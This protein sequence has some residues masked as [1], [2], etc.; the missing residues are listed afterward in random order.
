MNFGKLADKGRIQG[1][2]TSG[3]RRS[4]SQV[5]QRSEELAVSGAANCVAGGVVS[6]PACVAQLPQEQDG[7]R[8]KPGEE[9]CV[10]VRF[11]DLRSKFAE[12]GG[13]SVDTGHGYLEASL[14]KNGS[15]PE[16]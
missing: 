15:C 8:I 1:R 13:A 9:Q 7:L 10:W 16:R 4:L 14:Q 6:I 12:V 5:S 2:R 11:C 3:K